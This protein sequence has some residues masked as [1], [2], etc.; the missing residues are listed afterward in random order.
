M[1]S[2]RKA[3]AM[4]AFSGRVGR[5]VLGRTRLLVRGGA[6]GVRGREKEDLSW[7]DLQRLEG[8]F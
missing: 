4:A 5:V 6:Q 3:L 7:K 8:R 2:V 1:A